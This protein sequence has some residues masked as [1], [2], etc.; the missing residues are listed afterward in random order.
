MK[1]RD[2]LPTI[3]DVAKAAGVSPMTVSRVLN[4]PQLVAEPKRERVQAAI[5][6]L[7]YVVNELARQI[8]TGRH[9]YIGIL[10]L[11]VATTPYSVDMILAV[12]QVAREHGWRTYIVNAFTHD[13]SAGVLDHILAF[14]PEGVILATVGHHIVNVHE[15]LKRAG[16]VLASCQ[17]TQR[18]IACYVPDDEEGQYDGV[19]KLLEKGYRRPMCIHL[20]ERFVAKTLRL[21]GMQRAFQKFNILEKDQTHFVLDDEPAYM[22]CVQFLDEVIA[23][24][25]RPDCL[26]CGND[27]VAFVAYQHLLSRGLRIPKDIGILGFDNMVGVADLFLPPLSTI[28][29][30]N[31]EIGRAAALHIIRRRKGSRVYRIPCHFIGRA[32]F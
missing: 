21:K 4:N 9:P 18:G 22:Q 11:R 15:R 27:R 1:P 32:S 13:P 10:S 6:D 25:P 12:E 26:I 3:R 2:K 7:D 28:R 24:R 14:R 30:P 17:T 29:L 5:R 31:E 19:C 8:G 16:V 20:P 23:K